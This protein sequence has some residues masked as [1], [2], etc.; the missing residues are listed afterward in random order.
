RNRIHGFPFLSLFG[1][2]ITSGGKRAVPLPPRGL[3]FDKCRTAALPSPLAG[4]EALFT[5]SQHIVSIHD[6]GWDPAS[7]G[8]IG[9]IRRTL[10]QAGGHGNSEAVVF[11]HEHQRDLPDRRHVQGFEKLALTTGSVPEQTGRH[12]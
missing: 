5:D 10:R 11:A 9:D 12:Q 8:A 7:A 4:A 2:V 6:S 3:A 1:I